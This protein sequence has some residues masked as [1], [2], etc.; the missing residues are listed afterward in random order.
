MAENKKVKLAQFRLFFL[1]SAR[2][3]SSESSRQTASAATVLA[4]PRSSG[5]PN[6]LLSSAADGSRT[7]PSHPQ[8]QSNDGSMVSQKPDTLRFIFNSK[9]SSALLPCCDGRLW[10][11]GQTLSGRCGRGAMRWV[12]QCSCLASPTQAA[13]ESLSVVELL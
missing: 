2:I 9:R 3:N 6:L 1:A 4:A 7:D 10:E 5:C 8:H 13:P 11:M 12:P